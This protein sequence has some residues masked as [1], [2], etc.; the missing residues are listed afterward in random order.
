MGSLTGKF[1]IAHTPAL[2]VQQGDHLDIREVALPQP[3][4]G[5]EIADEAHP[6][7]VLETL[8]AWASHRQGSA[9]RAPSP[10]V[11]GDDR[12]QPG[13]ARRKWR[14]RKAA[15]L[16]RPFPQ[17]HHRH[18]LGLLL[19]ALDRR[20]RPLAERQARS[21]NP[22]LP[23]CLCG[24]RPGLSFGFWEPVRL[25]DVTTKPF[26]FPNLGGLTINPG[27]YVGNGHVSAARRRAA[28]RR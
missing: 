20:L 21:G 22:S 23:V 6:P 13:V 10:P 28:T 26:C 8:W 18:L 1:G 19:P 4:N 2:L 17:S 9:P 5:R 3:E 15:H 11:L 12:R 25:I 27:M 7:R 24:I 14:R 16:P